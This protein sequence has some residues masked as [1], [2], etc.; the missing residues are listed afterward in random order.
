M[1]GLKPVEPMAL[2]V[3][4]E[5]MALLE[6]QAPLPLQEPTAATLVILS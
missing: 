5:P 6:L 4:E 2:P 3:S 1:A